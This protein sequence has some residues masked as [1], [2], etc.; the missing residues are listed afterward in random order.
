MTSPN[1]NWSQTPY[2]S[3]HYG[4]HWSPACPRIPE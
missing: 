2:H 4:F 1:Y 3:M